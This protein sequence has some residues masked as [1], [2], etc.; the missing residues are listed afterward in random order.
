MSKQHQFFGIHYDLVPLE[1]VD[2]FDGYHTM[3]EEKR[4]E[5][6]VSVVLQHQKWVPRR[7]NDLA[8]TGIAGVGENLYR[9]K[10]A[11]KQLSKL[12]LLE[13]EDIEESSVDD[14]P[15]SQ[16]ICSTRFQI[17]LVQLNSRINFTAEHVSNLLN[18]RFSGAFQ[19]SGYKAIFQAHTDEGEFWEVIESAD[20][21]FSVRLELNSPNAVWGATANL[22]EKLKELKKVTNTSST[23]IELSNELGE[24][25]IRVDDFKN[26]VKWIETGSG[27]WVLKV[28][29]PGWDKASRVTSAARAVLTSLQF[30]EQASDEQLIEAIRGFVS[31]IQKGMF[32]EEV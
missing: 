28:K 5:M 24:L 11:K 2:L 15:Y 10:F 22:R 18:E 6:F 30:E 27:R 23:V 7:G 32:A 3:G 1:Q 25:L 29:Y 19:R 31:N 16:F 12:H 8:I 13:G 9:G 17:F 20:K 4:R 21:V 26:Y 14:W